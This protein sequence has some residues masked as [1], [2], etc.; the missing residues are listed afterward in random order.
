VSE[1][2]KALGYDVEAARIVR[3]L[4]ETPDIVLLQGPPGVGKSWLAAGIGVMWEEA[5]GSTVL[6]QGDFL[7]GNVSL[8]PFGFAMSGLSNAWKKAF[9]GLSGVARAGEALL[10]TAGLITS[11]IEALAKARRARRRGNKLALGDVEQ[12]I[13]HELDRLSRKKPMLLI[14]DNLHWWDARSLE[15]LGRLR[16]PRMWDAFHFLSDL[17]VLAVETPSPYQEVVNPRAHYGFLAP[18]VTRSVNLPRVPRARFDEVLEALGAGSLPSPALTDAVYAFSGG[19]LALASRCAARIANGEADALISAADSD[20]FLRRILVE[21]INALGERG[22]R[23]LVMLQIAA[24]LGLRFRFDE[25]TCASGGDESVTTQLLRDCRA[26]SVLELD[27]G[28]GWFAHD[29]YRKYFLSTGLLDPAGIHEKLLE[30]LRILRPADYELRC[31]NALKAERRQE[32]AAWAVQ[33][34]LQRQREGLPWRELPE[35]ILSAM[36]NL[37]PVTEQFEIALM[38]LNQYRFTECLQ[39]L[40]G[41]SHRLP[42]CLLAEVDYLRATCLMVTRSEED[43]A[44]ARAMLEG[45]LGYEEEEAEL[46]TRLMQLLLYGLSML[47]DKSRG[48][49]LETRLR[50]LLSSR[51][52]FDPAAE[53]ALY[54]LDRCAGRF[55]LPDR[56]VLACRDAVIHFSP[57]EG[58]MLIRRPVEYYRCLVNFAANLFVNARYEEALDVYLQVGR[59]VSEYA[60]NVFPRLDYVYMNTL[61]TQFRLGMVGIEEAVQRQREII[62]AHEVAG[63]PFHTEN[64]LAVYLVFA[65]RQREALRILNRLDDD[66][67]RRRDPS[68]SLLYLIRSNRSALR[69]VSGDVEEASSEWRSLTETLHRVPYVTTQY[70]IRRHELLAEVIGEGRVM[71]AEEFDRCLIERRPLEFGPLWLELGRG[72]HVPEIEWWR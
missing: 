35:I 70:M 20:D 3:S 41:I 50:R 40:A 61:L 46:G 13:L 36:G 27:D 18:S 21:R 68:P 14:A 65:G 47:V 56:A 6:A 66:L 54:T 49:T 11:S 17:R 63:D 62:A 72:F 58:D 32:A 22:R 23:A 71:A 19:H 45:W 9:A 38:H 69:F 25:L 55:H 43:R 1:L 31:A 30:C 26:E 10:G 48:L 7:N 39:A 4:V 29:F 15:L 52:P 28:V 59:L 34:A 44:N 33:A 67:M 64:A 2:W 57:S 60:P 53:D 5:G 12:D 8:Y 42:R 24:V 37:T 16:D 51:S